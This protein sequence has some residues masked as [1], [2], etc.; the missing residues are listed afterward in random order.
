MKNTTK[1]AQSV[2]DVFSRDG[3]YKGVSRP[4][5]YEGEKYIWKENEM[6]FY[7][8]ENPNC[9]VQAVGVWRENTA[10]EMIG[11]VDTYFIHILT[12]RRCESAW[13]CLVGW[14]EQDKKAAEEWES[15]CRHIEDLPN[16]EE[17]IRTERSVMMSE[18]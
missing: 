16:L 9:Q 13:G 2:V 7:L 10:G 3:K 12:G 1:E 18:K 8:R 15:L 4:V 14:S 11:D 6:V 17:I 5:V